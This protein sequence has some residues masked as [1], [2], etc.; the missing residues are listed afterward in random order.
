MSNVFSGSKL[1]SSFELARG[2]S[3]SVL[4]IQPRMVSADLFQSAREQ[5]ATRA[6]QKLLKGR[7][8]STVPPSALPPGR[9]VLYFYRSSKASE[10]VGLR[11]GKVI[12]S[13][14]HRVHIFNQSGAKCFVAYEDIRIR[15]DSPLV[16]QLMEDTLDQVFESS[17]DDAM[18]P[19]DQDDVI[20]NPDAVGAPNHDQDADGDS[21]SSGVSQKADI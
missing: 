14:A 19:I 17:L 12:S 21:T 1:L 13:E 8:P 5:A 3:P 6:I 2:Y 9:S 18:P 16:R 20:T 15:P 7:A 4:G 11:P 10:P